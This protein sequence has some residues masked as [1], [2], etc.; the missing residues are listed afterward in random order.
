MVNVAENVFNRPQC[1]L[2]E[3]PVDKASTVLCDGERYIHVSCAISALVT[4][5]LL[6]KDGHWESFLS[7]ATL[8]ACIDCDAVV[9]GGPP[10]CCRCAREAGA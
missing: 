1:L 7:G 6:P 3:V 9:M 5:V 4:L 2:C 8:R 10:R